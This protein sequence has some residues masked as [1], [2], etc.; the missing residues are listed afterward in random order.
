MAQKW[1]VFYNSGHGWRPYSN[2]T[3]NKEEVKRRL[4]EAQEGSQRMRDGW[5]YKVFLI[6]ETP[7]E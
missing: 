4:A 1:Q 6:E 5:E 2:K 3:G 7:A